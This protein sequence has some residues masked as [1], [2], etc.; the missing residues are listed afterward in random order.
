M[1]NTTDKQNKEN[2]LMPDRVKEDIA[3]QNLFR[4]GEEIEGTAIRGYD[5]SSGAEYRKI[6]GSFASSGFQASNLARAIEITNKMMLR[7]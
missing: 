7:I 6:V 2:S 4:E 3:R 5:F 1:T